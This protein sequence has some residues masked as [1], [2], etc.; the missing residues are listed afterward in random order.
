MTTECYYTGVTFHSQQPVSLGM[1]I[2]LHLMK[3]VIHNEPKQLKLAKARSSSN[4]LTGNFFLFLDLYDVIKTG[5]S[6]SQSEESWFKG[7]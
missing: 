3:E 4:K 6:G 5:Q 1:L 7:R 2:Q